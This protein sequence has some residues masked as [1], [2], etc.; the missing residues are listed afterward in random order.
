[1]Y[2]AEII[3]SKPVVLKDGNLFE[4]GFLSYAAAEKR[5]NELNNKK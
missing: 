1:M 4:K 5:A 2:I 3:N